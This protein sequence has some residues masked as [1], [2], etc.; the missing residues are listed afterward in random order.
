MDAV[1]PVNVE[2]GIN[3]DAIGI[4]ATC[5]AE[6]WSRHIKNRRQT[7]RGGS[8]LSTL[9]N[10]SMSVGIS[11][12]EFDSISGLPT[13]L[14][15]SYCHADIHLQFSSSPNIVNHHSHVDIDRPSILLANYDIES[16]LASAICKEFSAQINFWGTQ[17]IS[18]VYQ[19]TYHM[20]IGP[21]FPPILPLIRP[22][23]QNLQNCSAVS[24]ATYLLNDLVGIEGIAGVNK[25][26][27]DVTN[28]TGSIS[29]ETA[30]CKNISLGEVLGLSFNI[31]RISLF[32]LT[33]WEEFE[34]LIPID[35]ATLLSTP[36]LDNFG[37]NI[38]LQF[39]ISLVSP[40]LHD[41]YELH[42]DL[43]FTVLLTDFGLYSTLQM[44]FF[45]QRSFNYTK[46]Q[47]YNLECLLSLFEG[48]TSKMMDLLLR[49]GNTSLRIDTKA[50][51]DMLELDLNDVLNS[52]LVLF[53]KAF[54][55]TFT[56]VLNEVVMTPLKNN[57]NT[58][59]LLLLSNST[60][61][62]VKDF[63]KPLETANKIATYSALIAAASSFWVVVLISWFCHAHR[64]KLSAN[65]VEEKQR[66]HV[67]E[68]LMWNRFIHIAVRYSVPMLILADFVL[69]VSSN[70][71][72][73]S[74]VYLSV[75][76]GAKRTVQLP[77]I[78]IFN[79]SGCLDVSVRALAVILVF[80]TGVWP[81][82]KLAALLLVWTVPLTYLSIKKRE[83]ILI[84]IN[85]F[86]KWSLTAFFVLMLMAIAFDTSLDIPPQQNSV[87]APLNGTL[88]VEP[89]TPLCLSAL[90]RIRHYS[91]R[92]VAASTVAI[93]L[94]LSIGGAA[95]WV[96]NA[97][98]SPSSRPFSLIQVPQC[99]LKSSSLS[100][101]TLI[102]IVVFTL[103]V[104]A[105]PL[106]SILSILLLWVL[107][108]KLYHQEILMCLSESL[109]AWSAVDVFT[110]VLVGFFLQLKQFSQLLTTTKCA[111]VNAVLEKYFDAALNHEDVCAI[112]S[113]EPGVGNSPEDQNLRRFIK[114]K[115]TTKP[116][117]ILQTDV[118]VAKAPADFE[119]PPK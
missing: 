4:G 96:L 112:N 5:T 6:W 72:G 30:F 106:C 16:L 69:L 25:I 89:L 15:T 13:A 80:L 73:S 88:H 37:A 35:P 86:G 118:D 78:F 41:L 48:N 92:V 62:S 44:A 20:V 97:L 11:L 12:I 17:A 18:Y 27:K 87:E 113:T 82:L 93:C 68:C 60:C 7:E 110:A 1:V 33:S 116:V 98:N 79:I 9:E 19:R 107:P 29:R 63:R 46:A 45:P 103:T 119:K 24:A 74:G 76:T 52:V 114:H 70:T 75:T 61:P 55:A 50:E 95:G 57:F 26:M 56:P 67:S 117:G 108:V 91:L 77:P 49:L 84:L 65:S 28:N 111:S 66:K 47:C 39:D 101:R 81:Y 3:I 105:L 21:Q 31:T 64:S 59:L 85:M 99:I 109:Y 104:I 10:S 38:T 100:F 102:T 71:T 36:L 42:E 40:Q 83:V 53:N 23:A 115:L 14:N 2:N 43:T 34:F 51:A 32:G 94:I 54:S 58:F 22:G 90:A 8:V